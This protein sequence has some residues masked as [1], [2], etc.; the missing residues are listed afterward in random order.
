MK[1]FLRDSNKMASYISNEMLQLV[2]NNL[3]TKKIWVKKFAHTRATFGSW[4]NNQS[5]KHN[6]KN[7]KYKM[8]ANNYGVLG[9]EY[10]E[11]EWVVPK[12]KRSPV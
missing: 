6:I 2:K 3:E 10:E 4:L 9:I 11:V 7:L 12:P 5:N 8:S 1:R